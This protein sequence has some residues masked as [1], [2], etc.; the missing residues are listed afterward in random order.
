MQTHDTY[1]QTKIIFTKA[2][3]FSEI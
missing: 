3:E 2:A 1:I